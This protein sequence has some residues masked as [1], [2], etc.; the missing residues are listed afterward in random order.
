MSEVVRNEAG[1]EQRVILFFK[2]GDANFWF[3]LSDKG[4][5]S[6]EMPSVCV[7]QYVSLVS[8]MFYIK[9]LSVSVGKKN[10]SL[11]NCAS[12]QQQHHPTPLNTFCTVPVPKTTGA[13]M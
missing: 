11:V 9:F 2:A 13:D 5:S 10:K 7:Q 6:W 1:G 8:S 12:Y 4:S 3:S